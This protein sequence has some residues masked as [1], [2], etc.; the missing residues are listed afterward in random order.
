MP[1]SFGLRIEADSKRRHS[2]SKNEVEIGDWSKDRDL[3]LGS[4]RG[5]RIFCMESR[6]SRASCR[7]RAPLLPLEIELECGRD[8][9]GIQFELRG[10]RNIAW[11]ILCEF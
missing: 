4:E 9:C 5:N 7:G 2:G 6:H 1:V 11:L 8:D 3:E 10:D